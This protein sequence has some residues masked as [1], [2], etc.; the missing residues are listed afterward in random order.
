MK[1]HST[2]LVSELSQVTLSPK[3][4]GAVFEETAA[5]STGALACQAKHLGVFFVLLSI[6]SQDFDQLHS[7]L[8]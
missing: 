4:A 1:N 6:N 5:T 7:A 3:K 8:S 2:S